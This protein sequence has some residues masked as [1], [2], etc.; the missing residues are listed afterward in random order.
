MRTPDALVMKAATLILA[1]LAMAPAPWMSRF[2]QRALRYLVPGVQPVPVSYDGSQ[3]PNFE[4]FTFRE[5][6]CWGVKEGVVCSACY[7]HPQH[8]LGQSVVLCPWNRTRCRW[9]ST[10][11]EEEK[12]GVDFNQCMLPGAGG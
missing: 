5:Q 6:R 9:V 8:Y 4:D 7:N 2:E 12:W 10:V 3:P 1:L 11:P